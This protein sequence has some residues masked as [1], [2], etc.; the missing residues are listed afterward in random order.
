[1]LKKTLLILLACVSSYGCTH[2]VKSA[3]TG[4]IETYINSE[5]PNHSGK[6]IEYEVLL[7]NGNTISIVQRQNF[8]LRV[9]QRV[10]IVNNKII[11]MQ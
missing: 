11:P 2:S 7:D 4:R 8:N 9:G 5:I 3:N 6:F 10:K 1:M